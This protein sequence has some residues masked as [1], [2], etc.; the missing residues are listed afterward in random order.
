MLKRYVGT[1][2]KGTGVRR[3]GEFRK[4]MKGWAGG[5]GLGAS[6]E[7]FVVRWGCVYL[8]PAEGVKDKLDAA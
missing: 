3:C 7:G 1:R 4:N 2:I 8:I 6:G 5:L